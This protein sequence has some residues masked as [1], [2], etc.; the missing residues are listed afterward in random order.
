MFFN[1]VNL[2]KSC[3]SCPF[4]ALIPVEI[5]PEI[6][7][8]A[9]RL[10]QDPVTDGLRRPIAATGGR[11]QTR[12]VEHREIATVLSSITALAMSRE[13]SLQIERPPVGRG[14]TLRGNRPHRLYVR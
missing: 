11:L 6:A 8:M 5:F 3:E 13:P 14:R 1:P 10:T 9:V 7:L 2:E 12:A 4:K